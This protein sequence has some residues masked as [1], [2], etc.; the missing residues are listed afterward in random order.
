MI[1]YVLKLKIKLFLVLV[2]NKLNFSQF[3]NDLY[4]ITKEV[5]ESFQE[6]K[7]TESI[8]GFALYSDESASSISISLNTRDHLDELMLAN[9]DD[10]Q[11]YKWSPAE[12]K[13]EGLESN[14]MNELSRKLFDVATEIEESEFVKFRDQV[15]DCCVRVLMQM[16]GEKVFSSTD[17]EFVLMFSVS[18]YSDIAS[19]IKWV[20]TLN[21]EDLSKE[22]EEWITNEG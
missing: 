11:Y 20:N 3:E 4:K 7:G 2:M 1:Q 8:C 12:W 13:Y 21:D 15:F 18:D 6:K 22:F 17:E 9:P 16:K 14:R 19:E 5:F 10:K